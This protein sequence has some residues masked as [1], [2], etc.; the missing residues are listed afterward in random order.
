MREQTLQKNSK[1][2]GGIV[3]A[4][5]LIFLLNPFLGML[6]SLFV[7]FFIGRKDKELTW[8][9]CFFIVG[10]SSLV[11]MTA[12]VA[13]SMTDWSAYIEEFKHVGEVS[14]SK[15]VSEIFKEPLWSMLEYV[16]FYLL[17]G[18]PYAFV[19]LIAA[20][21]FILMGISIYRYW[22]YTMTPPSVLV[23]MLALL[24]FFS[25]YWGTVAN[26]LRMFFAMGIVSIGF[27]NKLRTGKTPWLIYLCAV[28]IHTLCVLFVA[29]SF[30]RPMYQKI[31]LKNVGYFVLAGGIAAIVMSRISFFQSIF[32]SIEVLSYG[33]DRLATAT[34][35]GDKNR[36]DEMTVYINAAV[37]SGICIFMNYLRKPLPQNLFYTNLLLISMLLCAVLASLTPEIMGRI[38]VIRMVLFPFVFPFFMIRSRSVNYLVT[39]GITAFF[40]VRFYQTFDNIS[41]GGLYPPLS[42]LMFYPMFSYFL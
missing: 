16:L 12:N 34:D 39:L 32:S 22:K 1:K 36:L 4:S 7:G 21:T 42:E 23:A 15:Y 3:I 13:D 33:F 20:S 6:L 18:N 11:Q 24:F 25:E 5:L 30:I 19:R 37:V 35:P 40:F 41:G 2:V 8:L 28:L 26:L 31:K 9:I 17:G 38:Y 29:V 27:V 14:F 10:F